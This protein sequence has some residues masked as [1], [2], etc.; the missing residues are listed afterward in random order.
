MVIRKKRADVIEK[1]NKCIAIIN[2]MIKKGENISFYSVSQK[3]GCAK[4]FLYNQEEIRKLIENNRSESNKVNNLKEDRR[5]LIKILYNKD[6]HAKVEIKDLNDTIL[7]DKAYDAK[8]VSTTKYDDAFFHI[9]L[10]DEKYIIMKY[11]QSDG[12]LERTYHFKDFEFILYKAVDDF[13]G[14]DNQWT[15]NGEKYINIRKVKDLN[16]ILDIMFNEVKIQ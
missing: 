9:E 8:F 6:Y 5:I 12:D 2:D 1:E 11:L 7:N 10:K 4:T 13:K 15:Y 3:C 16:H 14:E